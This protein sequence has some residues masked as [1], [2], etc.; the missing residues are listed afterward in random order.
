MRRRGIARR[1]TGFPL[2][3]ARRLA[4][5]EIRSAAAMRIRVQKLEAQ[6][7]KVIKTEISCVW[8]VEGWV[9]LKIGKGNAQRHAN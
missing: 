3:P 2:V 9:S 8:L 7:L 5:M 1:S 6:P 4:F